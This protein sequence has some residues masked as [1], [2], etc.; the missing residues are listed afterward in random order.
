MSG[1]PALLAAGGTGGHLFPAEALAHV[2]KQRGV[3]VELV[4]DARALRYGDSFPARAVHTIRSATPRGGSV[5]SRIAA[6]ARLGLGVVEALLLIRRLRPCVVIGFGGYPTVPPLIAASLLRVPT[7]LHEANGVMGKANR[8][9]ASRVGAIAAGFP[10][11]DAA[12]D[13]RDKIT[14]TGNPLRPNAL[15]AMNEPYPESDG[16]LRI[17]VTGGSQGARVMADVVPAAVAALPPELRE[18]IIVTQQARPE[19]AARVA[20]VYERAGVKAEIAPFFNDLP[21]RIARA[22][23]VIARSGASTVSEL[24][25][26]GRASI[27]VPLPH[28]LDQDQA[29]NA[30]VLQATGAAEV[31]R[32]EN[33]TPRF[34][35]ERLASF[36]ANPGLLKLRAEGAKAAGVAD[37]AERLADLVLGVAQEKTQ[38]QKETQETEI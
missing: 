38:D 18:K 7:V 11:S 15:A 32:Q 29:A 5:P 25:A 10:L 13:W 31:V 16:R 23:L 28:A 26:I 35:S 14:V 37:A 20:G 36:V 22:Q 9:L 12:T 8:F 19:D 33:F 2:L 27:L 24:A 6:V 21:L 34:L 4:T 17:L 1:G 30:A 3:A